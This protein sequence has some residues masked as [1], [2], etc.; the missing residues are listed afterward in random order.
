MTAVQP[1]ATTPRVVEQ[2]ITYHVDAS[3]PDP[4]LKKLLPLMFAAVDSDSG[5][6]GLAG[7]TLPFSLG[8]T[9]NTGLKIANQSEKI[10]P[11]SSDD[12]IG[13]STYFSG[14]HPG[15]DYRAAVGSAIHVVMPGLVSEIGF[16]RGGYG[17]YVIVVHNLEGTMMFSLYAHMKETSVKVGET[18]EVGQKIGEVGLT[19]H[20][21]G[22]HLHFELHDGRHAINPIAFFSNTAIAM[23][24][25]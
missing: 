15:I 8:D 16:E 22:P 5:A 23:A 20:T 24:R 11:I 14:K 9:I 1:A 13:I 25:K 7:E 6:N 10:V 17:R 3:G 12:M 18:V 2:P 4:E 19:G 21:T